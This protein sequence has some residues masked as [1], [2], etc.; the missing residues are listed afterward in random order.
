[1]YA[2]KVLDTKD[3]LGLGRVQVSLRGFAADLVLKDVWLRML[4]PYASKEFGFVFLPEVGDEVAVLRGEGDTI[5]SLLI[6]GALYNGANKPKG[7]AQEG[8]NLTK[9]IRTKT[10]NA[11][12]F[13]DEA[14]KESIVVT[15]AGAKLTISLSNDTKGVVTISGADAVSIK[16]TT[17][18]TIDSK[19]VTIKASGTLKLDGAKEVTVGSGDFTLSGKKVTVTG[20]GA[21]AISGSTVSLG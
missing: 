19:D 4:A 2:A 12:T 18:L 10:G 20:S 5:E 6:L 3:P 15:T 1:M 7:G 21:V 9:E 16:S 8:K 11:I 14:G 13:S 17:S